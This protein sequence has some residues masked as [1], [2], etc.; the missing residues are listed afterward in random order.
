MTANETLFDNGVGHAVD[1]EIYSNSVVRRVIAILNRVEPDLIAQIADARAR[2]SAESFTVER[3]DQLLQ[4]ARLINSQ[5]YRQ[6]Y[7]LMESE[8]RELTDYEGGFQ[9]Q[10]LT[11]VQPLQVALINS[12]EVAA[13]ALSRP[14]QGRLLREWVSGLEAESA[15]ALRD[16]VRIGYI[17]GETTEQ[18]VRRIRGT[19]SVRYTDGILEIQRRHA[20]TVVI[21]AVAHTASYARDALFEENADIVKGVR[22]T[23]TLDMRTTVLCASRDGNLYLTGKPKPSIP[24][25]MRCRSVY[26]PVTKSFAE[27]G[28]DGEDVLPAGMTRSSLDGYVPQT[29][30]YQKWL[31]RQSIERQNEVLGETKAKLFREGNLPL[32]RFIAR[33]G[34]E[35]TLDELR[36]RDAAAFAKAGL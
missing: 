17:E 6:V 11:L 2:L 12:G 18:I 21:T 24:A 8:M 26:V 28:L 30:T 29:T 16:A 35:Y 10:Q 19:R 4:S 25:H 34:H 5:A 15:R 31:E 14:F 3:L 32:T 9:A 27:L 1:L 33:D 23:A 20:K 36:A 22:Y 13:A 7:T